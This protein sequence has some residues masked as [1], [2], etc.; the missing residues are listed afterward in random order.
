MMNKISTEILNGNIHKEHE[1]RIKLQELPAECTD[2]KPIV[3]K[4]GVL[5]EA[6]DGND[7]V[8]YARIRSHQEPGKEP[9]YSLGVK[10]FPKAE[11][12]EAEISKETF[13]A[14][15]PKHLQKPQEK[16]RYQL[17]SGWEVN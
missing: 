16:K 9:K 6:K 4:Q 3:I 7:I 1:Q 2:I 10:N 5:Q 14:F 12:A 17:E 8:A 13:D 15:Y 11:E